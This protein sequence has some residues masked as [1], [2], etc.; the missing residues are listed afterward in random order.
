MGRESV[1]RYVEESDCVILLGTFMTDINLG[2]FTAKLDPAK[3]IYVTS[4]KLRIQHH[5][6]HDVLLS[7][8][9][10]RLAKTELKTS[11]KPCRDR[12]V[13]RVSSRLSPSRIKRSRSSGSSSGSTRRSATTWWWWPTSAIRCLPPRI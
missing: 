5:H 13:G 6:F 12:Q 9:V 11:R 7:D 1:R 10:K 4:E 2:I 8:F 3:C